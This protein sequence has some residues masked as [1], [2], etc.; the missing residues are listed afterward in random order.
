MVL[1]A[2][3]LKISTRASLGSC[4]Y[5]A[6]IIINYKH[7]FDENLSLSICSQTFFPA[8]A[9]QVCLAPWVTFF[10]ISSFDDFVHWKRLPLNASFMEIST[11]A[12]LRSCLAKMII[13]IHFPIHLMIPNYLFLHLI[14][15]FL[16]K[17]NAIFKS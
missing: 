4:N 6:K 5:M 8:L 10:M 16:A 13:P 17:R 1:N 14:F 11:C 3:S 2:S 7:P 12:T 9:R 15:P